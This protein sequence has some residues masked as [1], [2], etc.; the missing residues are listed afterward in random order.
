M[1]TDMDSSRSELFRAQVRALQASVAQ[2]PERYARL[3]AACDRIVRRYPQH[4]TLE[5]R[6]LAWTVDF[7]S[8]DLATL[9]PG[10]RAD[11]G[12]EVEAVAN[13]RSLEACRELINRV[14]RAAGEPEWRPASDEIRRR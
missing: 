9:G 12:L 2:Q 13:F 10:A 3:F 14:A 8:V 7:A 11:L 1:P 6:L 4:R 5:E